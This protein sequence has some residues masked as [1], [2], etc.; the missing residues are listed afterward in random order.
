[1]TGLRVAYTLTFP[2][3]PTPYHSA[4]G[5]KKEGEKAGR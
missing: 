4:S 5:V 1:M 2:P 3:P